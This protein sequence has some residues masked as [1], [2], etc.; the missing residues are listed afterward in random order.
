ME[1]VRRATVKS[2]V[3]KIQSV[4]DDQLEANCKIL[5]GLSDE[6]WTLYRDLHFKH[7]DTETNK[8]YRLFV[9]E[10]IPF[11]ITAPLYKWKEV[12]AQRKKDLGLTCMDEDGTMFCCDMV[13]QSFRAHDDSVKE[14][15][16][17]IVE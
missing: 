7:Y 9:E 5:T 15:N 13:I 12:I 1:D 17:L 11:P 2:T 4:W 6:K 14:N 16:T 8:S 10:G 3:A